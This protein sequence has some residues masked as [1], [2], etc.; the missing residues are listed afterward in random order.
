[1]FLVLF[2][3]SAILKCYNHTALSFCR[4]CS[5]STSLP[6]LNQH[7]WS[8][9]DLQEACISVFVPQPAPHLSPTL[10]LKYHEPRKHPALCTPC[11][12]LRERNRD[13]NS[14]CSQK[15]QHLYIRLQLQA[16]GHPPLSEGPS[17]TRPP[18][19][20]AMV[21]LLCGGKRED[22]SMETQHPVFCCFNYKG[23]RH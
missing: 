18:Q 4:S 1:M 19:H 20:P 17:S 22:C 8:A 10:L 12:V 13:L 3:T 15:Y 16:R 5:L 7:K 21:S 9:L 23:K 14:F 2:C 6:L 11:V